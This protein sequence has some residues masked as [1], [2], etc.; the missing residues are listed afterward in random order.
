MYD[1]WKPGVY[2]QFPGAGDKFVGLQ[3]EIGGDLKYGWL[4]LNLSA[5]AR[6]LTIYDYAYEDSGRSIAAGARP[7][8]VPEPGSLALMAT[9]ALAIAAFR[10]RRRTQLAA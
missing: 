1:E 3:F 9:G 5:D 8:S 10:R 6:S 2:G 7:S 4:R